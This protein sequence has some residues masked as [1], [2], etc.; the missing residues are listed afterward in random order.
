MLVSGVRTSWETVATNSDVA[1]ST[2][3][4][5]WEYAPMSSTTAS[6]PGTM[7]DVGRTD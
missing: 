5:R 4:P 6:S 3:A 7:R 1:R 2:V